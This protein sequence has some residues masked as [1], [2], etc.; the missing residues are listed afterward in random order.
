LFDV[1]YR[2]VAINRRPPRARP[3]R[4]SLRQICRLYVAILWMNN[5]ANETVDVTQR[6]EFLDLTRSKKL[7]I[8]ADRSGGRRVLRIFVHAVLIHR[9]P[10]IANLTETNAL[11][12][13]LLKLL[14]HFY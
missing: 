7:N 2:G 10:Q 3:F 5:A 8:D 12:G 13:L 1:E 11:T 4:Q 14:V 6:P 9:K